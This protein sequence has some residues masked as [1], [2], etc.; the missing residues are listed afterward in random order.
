MDNPKRI[1]HIFAAL[2]QGGV[3]NFVMNIYR[4]IDREKIQFD[5]AMTHGRKSFFDE[6]VL[7][8]GGRIFYFNKVAGKRSIFS[9]WKNLRR[10]IKEE[11]P[12][13]VIHS[14]CYFFS[15][16]LVMIGYFYNVPIRIVHSHETYKGQKYT[17][18]RKIYEAV[19]RFLIKVFSTHEFGCSKE[20]CI[21]LYGEKALEDKKVTVINNAIDA[22]K[23]VFNKAIRNSIRKKMNIENKFVVGNIG[24]LSYQKNHKFMLE[25]LEEISILNSDV[26]LILI[27]EGELRQ[28]IQQ[29]IIKM[30]LQDKVM[31][32]GNQENT[33]EILQAMD[34][35]L[36]PSHFEG[37]GIALVE[38]QASGLNCIASDIIPPECKITDLVKFISLNKNAKFW[39]NEVN[40]IKNSQR[41]IYTYEKIRDSGFDIKSQIRII[42]EFY[43]ENKK[44]K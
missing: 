9:Y 39:A 23:F 31:L 25:I 44:V 4:N 17:F 3:E 29:L 11:G 32:L 27:G 19:C 34:V 13:D 38:A 22:E 41:E 5:F 28:E 21:H 2:D 40:K 16:F 12:Y 6:E 7:E 24:R 42:E 33:Y 20:A 36:F 26:L 1:L 18:K 37:L 8:K 10:I 35:F 15:G 30:N 14:H 43:L